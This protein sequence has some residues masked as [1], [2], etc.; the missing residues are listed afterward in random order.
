MSEDRYLLLL[1]QIDRSLN[2]LLH[3]TTPDD[4]VRIAVLRLLVLLGLGG[5]EPEYR[6]TA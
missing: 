5:D 2:R 6:E 1:L 3:E 4:D